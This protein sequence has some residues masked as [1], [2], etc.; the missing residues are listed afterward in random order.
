MVQNLPIDVYA[1][2]LQNIVCRIFGHFFYFDTCFKSSCCLTSFN[3][4]FKFTTCF[5]RASFCCFKIS[6]SCISF[7][8]VECESFI[9]CSL[10]SFI[11]RTYGLQSFF[12]ID[13]CIAMIFF[14]FSAID[15]MLLLLLY[16]IFLQFL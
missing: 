16:D 10:T 14:I 4:T 7:V 1:S 12:S 9:S 6:L 2:M 3:A 11:P 13:F 8:T 15:S 5:I